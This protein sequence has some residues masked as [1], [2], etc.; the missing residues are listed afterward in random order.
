MSDLM[1]T[2]W[3]MKRECQ[4]VGLDFPLL[5]LPPFFCKRMLKIYEN[6]R[7]M[8]ARRKR[9]DKIIFPTFLYSRHI[10]R[11]FS[12]EE[13]TMGK[14]VPIIDIRISF[15][16]YFP[17]I[18]ALLCLHLLSFSLHSCPSKM[19]SIPLLPLA[20]SPLKFWNFLR[21]RRV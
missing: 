19:Y 8:S 15:A 9:L 13:I 3:L 5:F 12:K 18:R 11:V 6:C 16:C 10:I 1:E 2:K 14:S 7:D 17:I 4:S 20:I 21:L